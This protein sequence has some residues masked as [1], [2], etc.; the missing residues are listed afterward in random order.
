MNNGTYDEAANLAGAGWSV[1]YDLM[2]AHVEMAD[3]IHDAANLA[4]V[5]M[6]MVCGCSR[7][8]VATNEN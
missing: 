7:R 2:A 6:A 5:H 4:M 8:A 3:L 1:K